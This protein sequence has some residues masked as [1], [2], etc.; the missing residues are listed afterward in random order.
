MDFIILPETEKRQRTGKTR[1]KEDIALTGRLKSRRLM[2]K[3]CRLAARQALPITAIQF[4][5]NVGSSLQV[6]SNERI[7]AGNDPP[8]LA[9]CVLFQRAQGRRP[10]K[11]NNQAPM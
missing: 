10:L 9:R 5:A 2:G 4:P 1:Q 8:A 3:P 7:G 11:S 6:V